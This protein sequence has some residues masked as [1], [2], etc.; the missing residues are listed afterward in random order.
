MEESIDNFS[1]KARS[2]VFDSNS[3][4]ASWIDDENSDDESKVDD[5]TL[6]LGSSTLVNAVGEDEY[7]IVDTAP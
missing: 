7:I 3:N 1:N 5:A 6:S 4:K 2:Q